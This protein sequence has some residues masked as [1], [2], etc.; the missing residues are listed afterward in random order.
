[1]V[2][3]AFSFLL[4]VAGSLPSFAGVDQTLLSLLPSDS[5]SISGMD[6]SAAR[7]STLGQFLLRQANAETSLQ[8]LIDRTGFDPRRDLQDFVFATTA[9]ADATQPRRFLILARGLFDPNRISAS[10]Q[11]HGMTLKTMQGL[12]VLLSPAREGTTTALTFPET[13]IAAFGDLASV[14]QVLTNRANPS[15][16]DPVLQAQINTASANNDAWFA[17]SLPPSGLVSG[18]GHE[19]GA[20]ATQ[21]AQVVKSILQSNGGVRFGDNVQL[22]FNALARSD[23]DATSLT[24]VIRFFSST[25]QMQRDKDPRAAI[26]APAFDTMTLKADGRQVSTSFAIPEADLEK[27]VELQPKPA[28]T[29]R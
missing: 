17:S 1:M 26:L 21:G 5:Q 27:L 18:F 13:G 8:E 19:L 11:Q 4:V 15:V 10:A 6:V 24:D 29:T 9:Q 25:I 7:T 23:K 2:R 16:L 3:F 20:N 22:S 14:Q 12:A 28:R